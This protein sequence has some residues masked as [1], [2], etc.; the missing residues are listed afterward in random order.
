ML[1]IPHPPRSR[2][3]LNIRDVERSARLF[4]AELRVTY[5]SHML[6]PYAALTTPGEY[7][8]D[9]VGSLGRN[10]TCR[11]SR[12][13]TAI[14]LLAWRGAFR[15]HRKPGPKFTP[16]KGPQPFSRSTR[17]RANEPPRTGYF[18]QNASSHWRSRGAGDESRVTRNAGGGEMRKRG[19]GS[20][21]RQEK[22][23]GKSVIWCGSQHCWNARLLLVWC[24]GKS[25]AKLHRGNPN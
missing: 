13:H 1:I 7:I 2:L 18:S 15:V 17:P 23:G 11:C 16:R 14:I 5:R 19:C 24:C 20:S 6:Q 21:L 25:G 12:I 10:K 8:S 4:L 3:L 9:D 22:R